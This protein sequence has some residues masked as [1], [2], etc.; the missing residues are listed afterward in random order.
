[1]P[2]ALRQLGWPVLPSGTLGLSH[3]RAAS[4]APC[5]GGRRGKR[6]LA[7]ALRACFPAR[8]RV[9]PS[10]TGC[11][12]E[13]SFP[14]LRRPSPPPNVLPRHLHHSHHPFTARA[15]S[16]AGMLPRQRLSQLDRAWQLHTA[17]RS[18]A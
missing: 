12:A 16:P 7:A 17:G 10:Q 4:P 5:A 14:G 2:G 8:F 11:K 3:S 1:V 6:V 9:P 18:P 15:S 13:S